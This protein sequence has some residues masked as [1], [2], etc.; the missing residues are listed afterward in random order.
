[1]KDEIKNKLNSFFEDIRIIE[2]SQE[3][4]KLEFEQF[5]EFIAEPAFEELI[6]G[7][8]EM[9]SKARIIKSPREWILIRINFNFSQPIVFEYKLELIPKTVRLKLNQIVRYRLA[10]EREWQER[11]ELFQ[12]ES[13]EKDLIKIDKNVLLAHFLKTCQEHLFR[14][15]TSPTL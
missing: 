12:L 4:A 15:V 3:E 5:C 6:E 1:M 11:V 13:Q 8:E 10:K 7:L 14:F 2:Q 9:G